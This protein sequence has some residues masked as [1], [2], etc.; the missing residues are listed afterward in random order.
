[1]NLQWLDFHDTLNSISFC[2][3]NKEACVVISIVVNRL[4]QS[5]LAFQRFI[6]A[7]Q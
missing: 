4:L 5:D 1:M 2:A 7:E 6:F 3:E